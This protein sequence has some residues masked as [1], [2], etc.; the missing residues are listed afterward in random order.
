VEQAF[1]PKD[2][3]E[4]WDRAEAV[5]WLTIMEWP[6]SVVTAIMREENPS[7]ETL[8]RLV[9]QRGPEDALRV[10]VRFTFDLE[11]ADV[12]QLDDVQ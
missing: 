4:L 2:D 1:R 3:A 7:I 12:Y 11:V 8:R 10:I 5:R 6:P 9:Y